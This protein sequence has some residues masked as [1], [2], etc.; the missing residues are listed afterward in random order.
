M[1]D[2]IHISGRVVNRQ[3]YEL[4]RKNDWFHNAAIRQRWWQIEAWR[5]IIASVEVADRYVFLSNAGKTDE[6]GDTLFAPRYALHTTKHRPSELLIKWILLADPTLSIILSISVVLTVLTEILT[7]F[8]KT[9][10]HFIN[11]RCIDLVNICLAYTG[12]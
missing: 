7:V 2:L 6:I 4:E 9:G 8:R 10:N 11:T 3:K 12:G 5:W 1:L